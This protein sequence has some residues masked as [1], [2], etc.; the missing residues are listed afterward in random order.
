MLGNDIVDLQKAARES[1]WKRK[2]YLDKIF[3]AN[4][5]L[6]I[7]TAPNPNTMV[8][9]LWSMKEAAYKIVNRDTLTRFYS[10]HKFEC[11]TILSQNSLTE[12]SVIYNGIT[13]FTE[14]EINHNFVYTI[15]TTKISALKKVYTDYLKNTIEYSQLLH[16]EFGF[17]IQKNS[18]GIPEL[19]ISGAT[20]KKPISITHHGRYLAIAH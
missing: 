3:T 11:S 4:E 17:T 20:T 13:Y 19:T 9:L 8:W 12:G 18:F 10:P 1:N 7:L 5:Q 2:G 15:A 14:S 6:A 16:K